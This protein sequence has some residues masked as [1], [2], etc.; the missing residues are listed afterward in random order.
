MKLLIDT[1]VIIDYLGRKPPFFPNAERIMA[2]GYF[3]DAELWA[4]SQ[5]FKDAFF[6]LAHYVDSSSLQDAIAHLLEIVHPVDLTGEDMIAATQ[7]KWPDLEDCLIA[8][9]AQ[10]A[11][12]DYLVTRDRKGFERSP[13]PVTSPTEWLD[14]MRANKR[15]TYDAIEV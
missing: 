2:A 12:A 15:I 6:V 3:G 4:S 8:L 7:L 9:S 10:K 13:V 1:N 14:Y 11:K 5:S